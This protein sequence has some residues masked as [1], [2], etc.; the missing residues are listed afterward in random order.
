LLQELRNIPNQ[1]VVAAEEPNLCDCAHTST[2]TV[3]SKLQKEQKQKAKVGGGHFYFVHRLI[4]MN[5]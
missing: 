5:D 3:L 2:L 1:A 4:S